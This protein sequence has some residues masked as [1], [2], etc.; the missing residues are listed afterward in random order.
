MTNDTYSIHHFNGG[1]LG[2]NAHEE[3][4]R[5]IEQYSNLMANA[6]VVK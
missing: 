1:W 5:A 2:V 4:K 3:N 6:I